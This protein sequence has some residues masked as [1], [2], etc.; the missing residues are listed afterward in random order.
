M[1]KFFISFLLFTASLAN[2]Q[3]EIGKQLAQDSMALVSFLELGNIGARDADCKGTLFEV[4]NINSVIETDVRATLTK[5]AAMEKQNNPQEIERMLSM[6]KQIPIVTKDGKSAVQTTYDKLK[7]DN[8]TMY[9]KQA[10]CA[11]L[12]A[13]IR[14]VV[15]QRKQSIKNFLNK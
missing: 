15:Q 10:G 5:L 2:S 3:Q 12:S 4:T 13:T 8:F 1:K 7:Q 14:T 9:G 11:A 6:A